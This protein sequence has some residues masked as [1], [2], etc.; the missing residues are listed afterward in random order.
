MADHR[1]ATQ[2]VHEATLEGLDWADGF[3][4]GT[5]TRF[6]GWPSYTAQATHRYYWVVLAKRGLADKAATTAGAAPYRFGSA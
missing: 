4:C 3:A 6:G 2:H 1:V 5:P